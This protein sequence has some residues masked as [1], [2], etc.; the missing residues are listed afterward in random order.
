MPIEDLL[1]EL[2]QGQPFTPARQEAALAWL[3]D[4][5][6]RQPATGLGWM[7]RWRDCIPGFARPVVGQCTRLAQQAARHG[8]V[9]IINAMAASRVENVWRS[10]AEP[11]AQGDT[12]LH[13]AAANCQERTFIALVDSGIAEVAHTLNKRDVAG[14]T[15]FEMAIDLNLVRAVTAVGASTDEPVRRGL[16]FAAYR[17]MFRA[18]QPGREG[19]FMALLNGGHPRVLRVLGEHEYDDRGRTALLYAAEHGFDTAITAVA[20]DPRVNGGLTRADLAT[21]ATPAHLA[22]SAGQEG[23]VKAIAMSEN[24]EV[25]NTLA[26]ADRSGATPAHRAAEH[27]HKAVLRVLVEMSHPGVE[28]SLQAF[29]GRGRTPADLARLNGHPDAAD[30]LDLASRKG[31]D[32]RNLALER[33]VDDL[34]KERSMNANHLGSDLCC[35]VTKM[36]FTFDGEFRPV[37]LLN[38]RTDGDAGTPMVQCYSAAAVQHFGG[39]CPLTFQPFE[40]HADALDRVALMERVVRA[41]GRNPLDA[42]QARAE[43]LG[44]QVVGGARHYRD[45]MANPGPTPTPGVGAG[46]GGPQPG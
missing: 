41:Y 46:A 43:A 3:A 24:A 39:T 31:T 19:A 25:V 20:G 33:A 10:L 21:G 2:E 38:V 36:P 27:G 45:V 40:G 22:A 9:G 13:G 23:V 1:R 16:D 44:V 4:V 18:A 29:D 6:Q 42:A 28:S 32:P 8:E 5:G 11:D 37:R 15:P 17:A 35:P 30:M 14:R 12:P 7:E 26:A 34:S